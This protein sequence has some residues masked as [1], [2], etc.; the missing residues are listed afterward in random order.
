MQQVE[1]FLGVGEAVAGD[2]AA[3]PGEDGRGAFLD[4]DEAEAGEY[5]EADADLGGY[6]QA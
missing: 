4:P 1:A 3:D 5:G 2:P 6:G